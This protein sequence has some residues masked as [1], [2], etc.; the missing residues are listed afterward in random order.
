MTTLWPVAVLG[1]GQ[2][3]AKNGH[4]SEAPEIAKVANFVLDK[5]IRQHNKRRFTPF[6]RAE[7]TAI[8]VKLH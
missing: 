2:L 8:A 4:S 1:E 3:P 7:D 5:S 6:L